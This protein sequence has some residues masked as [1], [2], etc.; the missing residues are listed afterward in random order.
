MLDF[1]V[2][3]LGIGCNEQYSW[4]PFRMQP[5]VHILNFKANIFLL[6]VQPEGLYCFF[7]FE[8]FVEKDDW[9]LIFNPVD[10]WN[11]TSEHVRHQDVFASPVME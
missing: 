2:H 11:E 4:K 8:F 9:F 6:H 10:A 5:K 3:D 7:I 1:M